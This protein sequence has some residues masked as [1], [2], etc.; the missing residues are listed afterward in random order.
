MPNEPGDENFPGEPDAGEVVELEKTLPVI[1]V[2][3]KW[4]TSTFNYLAKLGGVQEGVAFKRR[5][6]NAMDVVDSD[7]RGLL[8]AARLAK[9]QIE[10]LTILSTK[11]G[12]QFR[13][14]STDA[15]SES[16]SSFLATSSKM[17]WAD[18]EKIKNALYLTQFMRT[19]SQAAINVVE[20]EDVHKLQEHAKY[21]AMDSA[22]RYLKN[23]VDAGV[24]KLETSK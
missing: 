19:P 3:Y 24:L 18:A 8:E 5:I 2:K 7:G 17:K 20:H 15:V 6:Q 21:K 10:A 16:A 23:Y 9:E 12:F 1:N 13:G 4:P 22:A 14:R 11:K